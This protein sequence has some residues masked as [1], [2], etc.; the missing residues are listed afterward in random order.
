MPYERDS[1]TALLDHFNGMTAGAAFGSPGYDSSL[2]AY[3]QAINLVEKS[4]VKYTF[5][6][7]GEHQGTI[8]MWIKLRQVP[9]NTLLSLQWLDVTS[10]PEWGYVGS[11]S[12]TQEGKLVWSP[13]HGDENVGLQ[14]KTTIPQNEWTHIALTWGAEGTKLYVNGVVDASTGANLWPCLSSP[15]YAYLHNWGNADL[16]YVDE[17]RISD[18]ARSAE[19]IRAQV[20]RPRPLATKR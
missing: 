3:G 11:L 14:G 18:V 15:T 13:W 19:E 7:W 6:G 17:F 8:E 1:H 5:L 16:G 9:Y 2:P 20:V 10:R 12:L 4:Y